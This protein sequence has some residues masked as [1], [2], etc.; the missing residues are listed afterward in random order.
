M[1]SD[2]STSSWRQ[3]VKC[4]SLNRK[5]PYFQP[6]GIRKAGWTKMQWHSSLC[7]RI[8]DYPTFLG[9]RVCECRIKISM[10]PCVPRQ[11]CSQPGPVLQPPMPCFAGQACPVPQPLGPSSAATGAQ[12]FSHPCPVLQPSKAQFC[13]HPCPV[14]QPPRHQFCGQLGPSSHPAQLFSQSPR[15][16]QWAL[17]HSLPI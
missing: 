12:F 4:L 2:R 17:G 3:N 9:H 10:R 6:I 15:W 5:R 1:T 14:P 13:S 7:L 16:A 8:S 11:F